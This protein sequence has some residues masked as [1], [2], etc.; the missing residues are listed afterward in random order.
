[1]IK[2][3]FFDLGGVL[4][5][6]D[7]ER[8]ANE[9]KKLGVLN[10]D[11]LYSKAT[12]QKLFVELE[13][14]HLS[15]HNF[16]DEIR[17]LSRLDLTDAQIDFAW[18]AIILDFPADRLKLLQVISQHYRCFLLSNTNLIHYDVY[19]EDLRINHHING[20]EVLFEKVY[21]SHAIGLRK[22]DPAIY[23]FCM[24]DSGLQAHETLFI[25]DS[26]ANLLSAQKLHWHTLHIDLDKNQ[27]IADYFLNGKLLAE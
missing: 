10:F 4:L 22:P 7:F 24:A 3:I 21:F 27:S 23:D 13:T 18:N 8:T 20:L 1:M 6:I 2:N 14:G 16:R 17:K 5:N 11:Q 26:M 15:P 19:Q 12:Q 25:D 9:F